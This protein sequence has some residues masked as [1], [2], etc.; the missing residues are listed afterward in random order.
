[1]KRPGKTLHR[2]SRVRESAVPGFVLRPTAACVMLACAGYASANPTGPSIAAGAAS[3]ATAGKTLN[4]TNAPGTIINWQGFSIGV[5]ETTRFLQQS[6]SSAVLNRV[7]GGDMSSILGTLNSNGRVFLVNPHGIVVGAGARIDTASFIASTLNITDN[8][9]LRGNFKFEGG[10]NGVLRNEGTIRASGDIMLVGPRIEN[11]GLI[12]SDNGAVLLA[13]GQKVTITSPDAQGVKFELQAPSDSAL[14]VGAIQAKTAASML[15]GTLKHSGDIRV[16]AAVDAQGR[17][18]LVA[19][20][21][22]TI[23]AGA[24]IDASGVRGGDVQILGERVAI[25]GG[26][27][28]NASGETGGGTI[29]VGGDYQGRNPD[30][31]NAQR[32][33]IGPGAK[34]AAD[35]LESGDG[36]E[37]IVWA[38]GATQFY[39]NISA[40]GGAHSGDGGFVETSGKERL[41]VIGARVDTSAPAGRTGTWLL[42][43]KNARTVAGGTNPPRAFADNAAGN[44]EIDP[45][46]SI[47]GSVTNVVMQASNDIIFDAPIAMTE[48]GVSFTAQA[49]RSIIVNQN[50]TTSDGDITLTANETT[51]AGVV[52]AQ[53]D[54]GAA[55]LTMAVGTS[56]NAGNANIVLRVAPGTGHAGESGNMTLA[57]VT[58]NNVSVVHNGPTANGRILR[59]SPTSLLT[60]TTSVHFEHTP[61]GSA[62]GIG[63]DPADFAIPAPMRIATPRLEAFVA[64]GAGGIFIESPNAGDL[65]IGGVLANESPFRGVQALAGGP[66]GLTVNGNLT[67]FAG[68]GAACGPGTSTGGPICAVGADGDITLIAAKIGAAGAGG[69]MH[70]TANGGT[71][72]ATSTSAADG[73]IFLHRPG[74]VPP[75]N[76]NAYTLTVAGAQPVELSSD[77]IFNFTRN[78]SLPGSSVIVE[79][80]SGNAGATTSVAFVAPTPG[81]TITVDAGSLEVRTPADAGAH[82]NQGTMVF[83]TPVTFTGGLSLE[84]SANAT[85]NGPT[86]VAGF[87]RHALGTLGG[88]GAVTL[89]G[90]ANVWSGGTIA[91]SGGVSASSMTVTGTP[92]LTGR[93]TFGGAGPYSMTGGT[94]NI[95]AGGTLQLAG[96]DFNLNNGA[97]INNGGLIDIQSD[98][99]ILHVLGAAPSFANTGTLRKSAGVGES[100]IGNPIN[101][102]NAATGL[103]DVLTGTLRFSNGLPVNDANITVSAGATLSTTGAGLTNSGTGYIGGSGTIDL[104]TATLVNN[105]ILDPGLSGAGTL[106]I[107][108]NLTQ[109]ATSTLNIGLSGTDVS[110]I[111]RVEVSGLATLGG[112]LNVAHVDGFNPPSDTSYTILTF[113]SRSG[114]F[115]ARTF[116]A[117]YDG[118]YCSP[119]CGAFGPDNYRLTLG[120]VVNTWTG[121]ADLLWQTPG[122]W[123]L[124]HAPTSGE[125]AFIG[126]IGG[127][128]PDD[129]TITVTAGDQAARGLTMATNVASGAGGL[130]SL[131][132]VNLLNNATL[133]ATEGMLVLNGPVTGVG[134][135]LL[136]GPAGVLDARAAL[137]RLVML[138]GTLTRTNA[139]DVTITG[140]FTVSGGVVSFSGELVTSG[141]TT[142]T[143]TFTPAVD[144]RNTGTINVMGG[145]ISPIPGVGFDFVNAFGALVDITTPDANPFSNGV[146]DATITNAG[147]MRKNVAGMQTIDTAFTNTGTLNVNA[148]TLVLPTIIEQSGT[149][150]LGAGT[151]L[152]TSGASISNNG[153]IAGAGTVNL[154]GVSLVNNARLRPTGGRLTIQGDLVQTAGAALDIGA[155]G[156]LASQHSAVIVTGAAQ[157]GGSTLNVTSVG[158]YVPTAGDSYTVLEAAV[159]NGSFGTINGTNFTNALFPTYAPGSASVAVDT[160]AP[161]NFWLP[162]ADGFWNVD[163]NWSLGVA[164]TAAHLARIERLGDITVT[165]PAAV[166]AAANRLR[167]QENITVFGGTLDVANASRVTGTVAVTGGT[168][169]GDGALTVNGALSLNA[170]TIAGTGGLTINGTTG[171]SAGTSQLAGSLTTGGLNILSGGLTVGGVLNLTGALPKTVGAAV[172]TNNGTINFGGG[173]PLALNPGAVLNNNPG[174]AFNVTGSG[175][176]VLNGGSAFNNGGLLQFTSDADIVATVGGGLLSNTGTFRKSA[177]SGA[178][179][180]ADPVVLT[181]SGG[182]DVLTGRLEFA[183]SSNTFNGGTSFTGPGGHLV[184]GDSTFGGTIFSNGLT[185]QSGTFSGAASFT[186]TTTWTGG[187]M[188]GA[189]TVPASATLNLSGPNA[190]TISGAAA[191]LTNAGALNIAGS[192]GLTLTAAGNLVNNGVAAW[193]GPASITIDAGSTLTNS[194]GATFNLTAAVADTGISGAGVFAN[195]GTVNSTAAGLRTVIGSTFNNTATVNVDGGTLRLTGDGVDTGAYVVDAGTT[196]DFAGGTRILGVAAGLTGAGTLSVS[197]GTVIFN[198]AHGMNTTVSGGAASFNSNL[199]D[200]GTFTVTGGSADVNAAFGAT[201]TTVSGGTA[202]FNGGAAHATR[203]LNLTG[204]TLGGTGNLTVLSDGTWS[205]G[206]VSGA[207]ASLTIGAGTGA[208]LNATGDTVKLVDSATLNIANGGT[209]NLTGSGNLV[210]NNAAALNNN[211]TLDIQSDADIVNTAGAAALTN[212]ATLRKSGGAGVSDIGSNAL[213]AMTNQAVGTIDV[214]T[215]TLRT[216]SMPANAGTVRTAAGTTF[217]TGGNPLINADTTGRIGGLGT[218]ATSTLVNN[219]TVVPGGNGAPPASLSLGT[220]T[221]AG[222]FMQNAGGVTEVRVGSAGAS[223]TLAVT[224]LATLGGR[225]ELNIAA[226]YVPTNGDTFT[227]VTFGGGAV[228]TFARVS[229]IFPNE[230][231]PAYNPG[232]V[233]TTLSF[234]NRNTWLF[235]GLGSWTD[236][237]RW[238]Q[239]RT[240]IAT[241][242]VVIDRP[243]GLFTVTVPAGAFAANTLTSQENITL[244]GALTLG[245]PST[246]NGTLT[247]GGGTVAGAGPLTVNGTT[248]IAAGASGI[249]GTLTTTGLAMTGGSLTVG[250]GGVLNLGAGPNTMTGAGTLLTNNGTTNLTGAGDLVLNGGATL[251][252]AGTFDFQTNAG[253][254]NTAGATG[255]LVNAGTIRK[256]AGAGTSTIGAGINSTSNGGTYNVAA[257]NTLTHAAINTFNAGTS[258]I[259]AGANV[260]TTDSTFNGAITSTGLA[261]TSGN[262][263]GTASFGGTTAWNGGSM[264]GAFTV[265]AGATLNVAGGGATTLAAA[266]ALTNSGTAN[267]AASQTLDGAFTNTG[268]VNVDGGSLRLTSGGTDTGI[269]AVDAGNTLDFGGGTRTLDAGAGVTGAGT[270]LVSGG[271]TNVNVA[272]GANTTILAGT[273]NFNANVAD[274]GTFTVSGGTANVNAGYTAT[275]TNVS[276]GTAS[277][278]GAAAHSTGTLNVTGGTVTGTG[279]L[280]VT[281]GGTWSGG[282]VSGAAASVTIASGAV[283]NATGGGPKVVDAAT[284]NIAGGGTV[285]VTGAAGMVLDN[286]ATLNNAGTL[287]LQTNAGI[288]H[289]VGANGALVNAGTI[290]KSA[291]GG[292]STIGAG[293]NST[294][295]GG[296]YNV[297]GGNTLTHAAVNTFNAGTSFTGAGTNIVTTDSTFNGAIAS[298]G[299]TLGS[300]NFGGV[301]SLGG[302]T[303]WNGGNM[304]GAFTVPAGSTLNVAGGGATTL[305]PAASLTNNGTTNFAAS[306]TINGAFNNAGAANVNGGTL[307][308]AGGGTD[309]GA[310]NVAAGTL[311]DLTG[312]TRNFNPG[313]TFNGT[314]RLRSAATLN[315]N[316]PLVLPNGFT[317]DLAGGTLTDT[318][319]LTVNG[320]F[321]WSAGTIAGGGTLTTGANSATAITGTATLAG[322]LW[323]NFGPIALTGAGQIVLGGAAPTTFVNRGTGVITDTSTNALPITTATTRVG[324]A[325]SNAGTFAKNAGSAATQTLDVP[326]TNTGTLDVNAG[327]LV[328]NGLPTNNGII[329]VAA[330]TTFSTAG[331]PLVNGG[332]GLIK[333]NGTVIATV[334]IN[335]GTV[336]PGDSPGA[337]TIDGNFVQGPLGTIVAELG[338]TTAGTDYDLLRVTGAATLDG[339]LRVETIAGAPIPE[340]ST[341]DFF[342]YGSRTG[343]FAVFNVPAG[344]TFVAT[345]GPTAYRV[346]AQSAVPDVTD[347]TFAQVTATAQRDAVIA[348]EKILTT[349]TQLNEQQGERRNTDDEGECR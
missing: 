218:V 154:G 83:N 86:T 129:V 345:A 255:A 250:G 274:I 64:G 29:L 209:L 269:Y 310:Y 110:Q 291:G 92:Q 207:G 81:S 32:T 194:A 189:F 270:L 294:S 33:Y 98:A 160:T 258:F 24:S 309:T 72:S 37:V 171:V 311:V 172:V 195:A 347:N 22:A 93:L 85:F 180:I 271:T 128:A 190:K 287:D 101:V 38:D 244:L 343:D 82:M 58:G 212:T 173:S 202:N 203:T 79:S 243:V 117:G 239:D 113:G 339:A 230:V 127:P 256:S 224:G 53:R 323:D 346:T 42:D 139:G 187:T 4:V 313:T 95:A 48:A 119:A 302:T 76:L 348:T 242:D 143:G 68:T 125:D 344:S 325:F 336:S 330:G 67:R 169:Q 286:G 284:L 329:D 335:N 341:F 208:V 288:A 118:L 105:G 184:M 204:G 100:A 165:V 193:T 285:N 247:L 321:N 140:P 338:G 319:G 145:R 74:G 280:G 198:A 39:G 103:I 219:G 273:A 257:G 14:N 75:L 70:V 303:G 238:S 124:G 15:A 214:L 222:D 236:I 182:F 177:G 326:M 130:L 170:A 44:D 41:S 123:S 276:A 295:N 161:V 63:T 131:G 279:N 47:N 89:N 138:G 293:I 332:L 220:L 225:L 49:G 245:G 307:T 316:A 12:R 57:N 264:I 306:Q 233:T 73:G 175:D 121:A 337:L 34:L 97:A 1:M 229:K 342:T 251:N 281:T 265:P 290:R 26:A 6:A 174:A 106:R 317:F 122:N 55:Q 282:T 159:V 149:I 77:N 134:T 252:N 235:D 328:A 136:S 231:F 133:A 148:G 181:S 266:A 157:L 19:Q 36:G 296:T 2:T 183:S 11:A 84:S 116:P 178:T 275:T 261:L 150:N 90:P 223:D 216:N 16:A 185:L 144:W 197:G 210:L 191:S 305:A 132:P 153:I 200:V 227:A 78:L 109:G 108:G 164:P 215:G 308:L 246:I 228:G 163:A 141:T 301:A 188:A 94:L 43:P 52:P 8:D 298:T 300:G 213:F 320:A 115:A 260:V 18:A 146:G 114:D 297:A 168:L 232:S 186:G 324:K 30:V 28:V 35:A 21:E 91:G 192:G 254:S 111:D 46:S 45:T 54:A 20:K 152:S 104:G 65:E 5:G 237:G 27:S 99:D 179:T 56:I 248:A 349:R 102:T 62:A 221:I 17:V 23:A 87:Y 59:A 80:F 333:G 120:S 241:D 318:A 315:V 158:G 60:G 277:F 289:T 234:V 262:F 322:K 331:A 272:H 167:S 156:D 61:N 267:F 3:F 312:G 340:G 283:F 50:I 199:A 304:T 327:T 299:L 155:S 142:V 196:L 166:T 7:V 66:I 126:N 107:T 314:G 112:T 226:G 201:T 205:A 88:T 69:R 147:T 10:G 71:V 137:S 176:L 292:T 334:V 263:A 253:I 249:A 217:A 162:N 25:E 278:N 96:A 206:S 51:G 9:F 135:L 259:G 240:P 31:R 40:R 211:G 268:T 13:A 151:T